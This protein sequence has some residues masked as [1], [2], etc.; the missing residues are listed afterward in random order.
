M[1]IKRP[2]RQKAAS[3]YYPND[4]KYFQSSA[5]FISQR[6]LFASAPFAQSAAWCVLLAALF[7]SLPQCRYIDTDFLLHATLESCFAFATSK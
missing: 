4:N 1:Q 5:L 6:S 3:S 2:R 7:N